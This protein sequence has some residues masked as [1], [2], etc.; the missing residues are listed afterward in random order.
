[1]LRVLG[2]DYI[3][4]LA[5]ILPTKGKLSKALQKERAQDKRKGA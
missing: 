4:R 1:V 2:L 3:K 5:G